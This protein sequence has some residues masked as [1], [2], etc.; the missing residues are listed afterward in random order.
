MSNGY[1][2]RRK[3]LKREARMLRLQHWEREIAVTQGQVGHAGIILHSFLAM[4][5]WAR[6]WWLLTGRFDRQRVLRMM[7]AEQASTQPQPAPATAA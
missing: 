6:V 4:P 5:I 1:N 7:A 3:A 2:Q